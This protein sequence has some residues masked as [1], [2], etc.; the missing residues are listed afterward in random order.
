MNHTVIVTGA[1]RGIGSAITDRLTKSGCKVVGIAR[2]FN[3]SHKELPRF[4]PYS[5]D[6]S[7]VDNLPESL[8]SLAKKHSGV[9][10]LICNAGQGLFGNLEELS[11]EQ[12]QQLMNINFLSHVYLVK[13]FLPQMKQAKKGN[14]ILIGSEAALAGRRQGSIYCASKFALRGF[15]QALREECASSGIR[16]TLINPGMVQTSFFD[17]LHFSP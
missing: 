17:D 4:T 11:Y 8:K 12:I 7:V 10:T 6:L 5:L 13:A 2:S 14:I 16:V 1:S 3:E 15:T 9:D